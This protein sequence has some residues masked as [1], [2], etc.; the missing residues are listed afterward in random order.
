M[1]WP[2]KSAQNWLAKCGPATGQLFFEDFGEVA[3]WSIAAVSK[4][5]IPARVSR[6][7]IPAS[8]NNSFPTIQLV[9]SQEVLDNCRISAAIAHSK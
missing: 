8:P 1:I 7:R 2:G 3:E 5:V 4:T 9:R 6:V